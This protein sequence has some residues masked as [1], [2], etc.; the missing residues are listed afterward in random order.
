MNVNLSGVTAIQGAQ[1]STGAEDQMPLGSEM[2][3]A[4]ESVRHCAVHTP[5]AREEGMD[6][7]KCAA[8][9]KAAFPVNELG[10]MHKILRR[11]HKA[12]HSYKGY[13]DNPPALSYGFGE[14]ERDARRTVIWNDFKISRVEAE[15][16][17]GNIRNTYFPGFSIVSFAQWI[18]T[19]PDPSPPS[20]PEDP[21]QPV[22]G[23]EPVAPFD[24][25]YAEGDVYAFTSEAFVGKT[26]PR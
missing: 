10:D 17:I 5:F 24:R 9:Y 16:D 15:R 18:S 25:L 12:A 2:A 4:L 6:L 20:R 3:G 8:N 19:T 1:A 23:C 21:S 26:L 11:V 13:H 7:E 14:R 22:I